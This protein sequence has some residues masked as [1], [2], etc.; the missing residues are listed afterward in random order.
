MAGIFARTGRNYQIV[1]CSCMIDPMICL[2]FFGSENRLTKPKPLWFQFP[3]TTRLFDMLLDFN[4][5][6]QSKVEATER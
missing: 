5:K 1:M 2:S 4:F 6:H 3:A